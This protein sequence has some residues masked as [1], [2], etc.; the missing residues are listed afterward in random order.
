[1]G[2]KGERERGVEVPGNTLPVACMSR[3]PQT[4]TER[5]ECVSE[6]RDGQKREICHFNGDFYGGKELGGGQTDPLLTT[7]HPTADRCISV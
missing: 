2:V 7:V 4:H 1:M 6:R 5:R 3:R